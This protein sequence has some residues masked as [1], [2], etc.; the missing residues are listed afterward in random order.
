MKFLTS[1]LLYFFRDRSAQRNARMLFKFLLI[2]LALIA[3]YSVLFHW[4]MA[5]EGRDYSWPS[6]VYWTLTVMTTLGFG[7]ITFTSDLGR[8]FSL[9]VLVSGVVFLLVLLPFTFIQFFYAPWLEAQERARTPRSLPPGTQGH[10]ILSPFDAVAA[11]LIAKLRQYNYPYAV[12]VNDQQMALQLFDQGYKAVLGDLDDRRTYEQLRADRASLIFFNRGDQLNTNA[13]FTLR[14]FCPNTPVAANVQSEAAMDIMELAG[15]DHVLYFSRM[16]GRSLARRVQ[17]MEMRAHILGSFD[18]LSIAEVPIQRTQLQGLSILDSEIRGETGVNVAGL[19]KRG[20]FVLPDPETEIGP[21]S[22]LV[23]AGTEEQLDRFGDRFMGSG[24]SADL[25]LILGGGRVGCAAADHLQ[26]HGIDHRILEKNERIAR[27][28]HNAVVGDAADLDVLRSAGL[29]Q[30]SSVIVTTN[31]D[32]TNI[33][34]TIYCRSLRPDLQIITRAGLDRNVSQLHQA[35]ADL[36]MSYAALGAS[37]VINSLEDVQEIMVAEGLNI[38]R[39][40]VPRALEGKALQD[41]G[42]RERTGCNVLAVGSGENMSVNPG[43]DTV[44]KKGEEIVLIGTA[45]T[46]KS[47]AQAFEPQNGRKRARILG[48]GRR[49]KG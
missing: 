9:I 12:L 38:F 44:L 37:A 25:V 45:K 22:V 7:D 33:Y 32:N 30:A 13:I 14:E 16:L 3:L 29:D 23:L 49:K 27:R 26:E 42:I 20:S 31:D 2:L 46:E 34:L 39:V 28:R 10:V 24:S 8:L 43:P 48:R 1:Q 19:W 18:R 15:A 47:F 11:A 40:A 41:S 17:G 5:L 35:G 6:S 36:V 21:H 4:I